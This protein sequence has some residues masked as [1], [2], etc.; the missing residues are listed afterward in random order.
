M[1]FHLLWW[2]KYVVL[3]ILKQRAFVEET[4]QLKNQG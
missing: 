3:K 2:E 1:D 4:N